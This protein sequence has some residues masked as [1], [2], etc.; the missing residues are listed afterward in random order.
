M[1]KIIVLF[2]I[3]V[4]NITE[5][6]FCISDNTVIIRE[7]WPQRSHGDSDNLTDSSGIPHEFQP[8]RLMTG[9][10]SKQVQPLVMPVLSDTTRPP[11]PIIE[12][13]LAEPVVKP[14]MISSNDLVG[15]ILL[16]GFEKS[17]SELSKNTSNT[18][19]VPSS[20]TSITKPNAA[21]CSV[22][23][24]MNNKLLIQKSTGAEKRPRDLQVEQA[25]AE[26][27][28]KRQRLSQWLSVSIYRI[29]IHFFS[30]KHNLKYISFSRK[31][32]FHEWCSHSYNIIS[33]F[34]SRAK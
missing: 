9:T 29:H 3:S 17:T 16:Q 13:K 20:T 14:T 28:A 27:K 24:N 21:P 1:H 18:H 2:F 32:C 6:G 12:S 23:W 4:S 15:Q 33:Y 25:Q 5:I 22:S 7:R 8:H 10:E 30:N 11:R 34:S 31:T 19:S 26:I